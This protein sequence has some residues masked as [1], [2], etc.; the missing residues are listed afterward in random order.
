MNN[1]NQVIKLRYSILLF[2]SFLFSLIEVELFASREKDKSSA[3][4]FQN[5]SVIYNL[6]NIPQRTIHIISQE[7]SPEATPQK[8]STTEPT[9][10]TE[11][12]QSDDGKAKSQTSSKS[13]TSPENNPV[14]QLFAIFG[15]LGTIV[16]GA[17]ASFLNTNRGK[18][19]KEL[20]SRIKELTIVNAEN[21][22]KEEEISEKNEE[23]SEKDNKITGFSS[24]VEIPTNESANSIIILG[25]SGSGKTSLINKI[26]GDPNA[27]PDISTNRYELFSKL[28]EYPHFNPNGRQISRCKL[29]LSDYPGQTALAELIS[30]FIEQQSIPFSPMR[31]GYVNSLIL[32]VD[33]ISP[34]NLPDEIVP[35]QQ[36][37]DEQRIQDNINKWNEQALSAVFGLL[38][39]NSSLKY[40]C[41]FI[42]KVDLLSENRPPQNEI[43]QKYDILYQ[44]LV[45]MKPRGVYLRRLVGSGITGENVSTLEEDLK[46]YSVSAQTI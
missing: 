21:A 10:E 16:L 12:S 13:T 17:I 34:P 32:I 41:L 6:S 44:R 29:Y 9:V 25:L 24:P 3:F 42:N 46:K 11:S 37:F 38:P 35:Q 20:N 45:N 33:L 43:L 14:Q 36:Q 4:A 22:K 7:A 39:S 31:F 15:T 27:N 2:L 19:Q 18:I 5:N 26:T 30:G 40:I 23:I 28:T 8:G 1:K